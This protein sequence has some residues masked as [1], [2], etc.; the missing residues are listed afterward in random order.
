MYVC[1]WLLYSATI[2]RYVTQRITSSLFCWWVVRVVSRQSTFQK[3]FFCF[4]SCSNVEYYYY[5]GCS[6]LLVKYFV[7]NKLVYG[8]LLEISPQRWPWIH[9]LFLLC[10]R[11]RKRRITKIWLQGKTIINPVQSILR[12]IAHDGIAISMLSYNNYVC[13]T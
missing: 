11:I 8:R 1:T 9:N 10:T 2:R 7:I 12:W 6:T 4:K 3:L 5:L 13:T